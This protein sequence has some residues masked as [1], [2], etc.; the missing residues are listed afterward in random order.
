MPGINL[1]QLKNSIILTVLNT[2]GQQYATPSAVALMLG[3]A[4]HESNAGEFVVQNGGPALGIWQMEPD[5]HDDCWINFL[6]YR[7]GL[8]GS[9][10][11]YKLSALG[12]EQMVYNAAY[13]CAMARVKY[14]RAPENLPSATDY[15]AMAHYYKTYYNSALG[16]A[17]VNAALINCFLT[18]QSVE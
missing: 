4:I 3:T 12:A 16:A 2:L 9:I 15:V 13:A 8:A 14:Y 10:N 5:T 11:Q 18:A 1:S 17:E 6:A 7:P